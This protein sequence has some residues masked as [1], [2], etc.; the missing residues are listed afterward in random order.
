MESGQ[1]LELRARVQASRHSSY[2]SFGDLR[3]RA[4]T[5]RI[6]QGLWMALSLASLTILFSVFAT[7]L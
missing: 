3:V 4:R 5:R 6:R 7:L 2:D 1:P